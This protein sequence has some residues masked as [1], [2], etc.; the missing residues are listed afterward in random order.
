MAAACLFG[1]GLCEMLVTNRW[2]GAE[3]APPWLWAPVVVV[4][5]VAFLVLAGFTSLAGNLVVGVLVLALTWRHWGWP[6]WRAAPV[7]APYWIAFY[8]IIPKPW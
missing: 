5:Y 7:A 6:L 8:Q 1:V 2:I 4:G 3:W